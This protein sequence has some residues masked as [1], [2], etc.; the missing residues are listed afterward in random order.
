MFWN[1]TS[2]P[3]MLIKQGSTERKPF[4]ILKHGVP[5]RGMVI[6]DNVIEGLL[7]THIA[8]GDRRNLLLS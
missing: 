4:G 3:N 6:H 8:L 7:S 2:Y 5:Y 1:I